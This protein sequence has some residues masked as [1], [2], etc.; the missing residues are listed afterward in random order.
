MALTKAEMA[1]RLFEEVGLFRRGEGIRRYVFDTVPRWS[2]TA[3]GCPASAISTAPQ[4]QR[5]AQPETGEDSH[6]RAHRGNLSSWAKL[7]EQVENYAGSGGNRGFGNTRQR[8]STISEISELCDEAACALLETIR[9][10][11]P[12]QAPWQ[13]ALLPAPRCP[14]SA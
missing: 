1:D 9:V 6:Y 13:P 2:P 11:E 14:E 7:K 4:N 5:R 8:Y 3:G 10:L 12:D